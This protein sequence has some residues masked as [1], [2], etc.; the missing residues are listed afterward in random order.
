MNMRHLATALTLGLLTGHGLQEDA[1]NDLE[2]QVLTLQQRLEAV[3]GY[4]EAQVKADKALLGAIN[5]SVAE[6]FTAGINH[7]AKEIL[8][9]AWRARATAAASAVPGKDEKAPS[10]PADP[11]LRRRGR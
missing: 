6:G 10:E 4:L 9:E 1:K 11:R 8:V 7:R 2:A 3:E 5:L